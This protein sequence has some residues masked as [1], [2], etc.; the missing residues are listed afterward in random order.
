[1]WRRTGKLARSGWRNTMPEMANRDEKKK[2][3]KN[4]KIV[5]IYAWL[6]YIIFV[7]DEVWEFVSIPIVIK[8]T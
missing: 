1:M 6:K 3:N 5:N 7:I 4:K 8:L 2:T